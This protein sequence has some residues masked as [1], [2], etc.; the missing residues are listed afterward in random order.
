MKSSQVARLLVYVTEL[1]NQELLLQVEYLAAKNR[2][3]RTQLPGRLRLL[4]AEPSTLAEI[5]KRLGRKGLEKVAQV[6]KP[7]IILGRLQGHYDYGDGR[8]KEDE[9]YMHFSRRNCNYPQPKYCKWFLTQHRRWGMTT[10]AP[11]YEGITKQVMRTDIYE[12][13]MKEIGCV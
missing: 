7:E 12:E 2:I 4:N 1:V 5:G 8:K 11:D 3:L 10:G 13:A 9:F 6:A